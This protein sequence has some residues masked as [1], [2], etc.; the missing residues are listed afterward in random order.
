MTVPR[1]SNYTVHQPF[2]ARGIAEARECD[3]FDDSRV[4]QDER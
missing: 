2:G 1:E 4:R 3:R